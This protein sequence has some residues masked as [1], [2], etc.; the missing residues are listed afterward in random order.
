MG[1]PVKIGIIGCGNI[2]STYLRI[3]K[4]FK[5]LEVYACAD[6]DME[7]AKAKAAEF[8]VPHVH[9]VDQLL[10]DP[11]IQIVVNLTIP[12]A[13]VEVSLAALAAGKHIYTEKPLA[14]T[15][16]AGKQIIELAEANGLLVGGA[17]DTFLGGGL[18]TCRKLIDEGLIGTPVAAVAFLASHGPENWHPNPDFFYQVGGGP[19]FDMGPYYLTTL[20]HL[21]GAVR[22]VTGSAQISFPERVATSQAL[23]GHRIPVEIPTHIAGV[24]DFAAGAVATLITSFDV[25][26]HTLPR[27]EIYGSEGS[28]SVPDPNTFGGPV[29]LRRADD[30][31]WR[32]MPLEFNA[33]INRGIGVAD[34]AYAITTGRPARASGALTYHVLDVMEALGEASEQG[35]HIHIESTVERPAPLPV[36]LPVDELDGVG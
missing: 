6:L 24:L 19:L 1:A 34:L 3:C 17:P 5:I 13:H 18:Q 20:V 30:A 22:R 8:E 33:D 15:R 12:A 11:E 32:E 27:V 21:L 14:I 4:S 7:R 10:A 36:G 35:Q 16:A 31:E 2:S 23:N 9:T 28:L 29:L 26:A 25:W